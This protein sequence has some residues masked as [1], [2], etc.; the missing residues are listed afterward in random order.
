MHAHRIHL[1]WLRELKPN[2]IRISPLGRA[3][4]HEVTSHAEQNNVVEQ[5]VDL[6]TGLVEHGDNVETKLA[7]FAQCPK[8]LHRRRGV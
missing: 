6:V 3:Q 4:V 7:D 8:H 2:K 1:F 5:L